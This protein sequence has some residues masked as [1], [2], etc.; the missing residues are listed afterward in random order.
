MKEY[1][2]SEAA[3]CGLAC[4]AAISASF[5]ATYDLR[6]LRTKFPLSL[7]GMSVLD[8]SRF[9]SEIGMAAR[10]LKVHITEVKKLTLPC[11]L[12]WNLNHF[13]VLEK[14]HRNSFTVMDPA[15][16]RIKVS[17]SVFHENFTG[18]A[19][20]FS[21]TA[22]FREK[23][24]RRTIPLRQLTGKVV[25]LKR[26]LAQ[27]IIFAIFLELIN[28]TAPLMSRFIVDDVLV[29]ADRDLL[30][31]II[32]GY[33]ILLILQTG[34]SYFRSWT[35]IS[36]SQRYGFQ[37]LSNVFTHLLRLPVGYFEKRHTGD[38]LSRF[39]TIGTIQ[40]L[41]TSSA[42][43]GAMDGVMALASLAMMF[44]VSPKLSAIVCFAVFLYS[45]SRILTLSWMRSTEAGRLTLAAKESTHFVETIRSIVP[46]RLFDRIDQR[47]AR[48]QNLIIDVQN[49]DA[50]SAIIT[51]FTGSVNKVIFGA[52]N[53]IIFW[54]GARMIL[55]RTPDASSQFTTGMLLSF[56]GYKV[57]F[58]SR[59]SS[60]IDFLAQLRLLSLYMDRLGDIVSE[61]PEV[62]LAHQAD[63]SHL[64]PEI[65]F[66]NISFRYTA[67]SP[68]VLKNLNFKIFAG[69]SVAIKGSSGSGK[70]TLLKLLLG[71][72]EPTSGDILYG[73]IPIRQLGLANYRRMIGA[74][75]QED[76]LMS[77][78][79]AE[80][81]SFFDVGPSQSLIEDCAQ[82][83]NIH[84]D[85]IAMPM[86][87]HSI[88]GDLG[89]GLSGGQKQRILLARALYKRPRLLV[90]DEATSHLDVKNE[91]EIS[92]NI[93]AQKMT[94][95]LVAHRPETIASAQRVIILRNGKIVPHLPDTHAAQDEALSALSP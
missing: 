22:T 77:G 18:I 62:D 44:M 28:L 46:L 68:L 42:V 48:W 93:A 74:V 23:R 43:E 92:R 53:L 52:E 86:G 67:N 55:E 69:E 80:N 16:G 31:I 35:L 29:S 61:Q 51:I 64:E 21:K 89:S 4:I 57:Q 66:R 24:A 81:I 19:I 27:V 82:L 87:Y 30:T 73:G 75:M 56:V 20:E 58:T 13:V 60:L 15:H 10:P 36:I 37:W 26:A 72:F 6:E 34:T 83:A 40:K 47:R 49:Y 78:S 65:E 71:L 1:V 17:T 63:I 84:K 85:I 90:L 14:I 33:A 25:G 91:R 41:L 70:T 32:I 79:L 12:H 45:I 7:K 5:G 9:S 2:Q 3:E 38:I 88:V 8:M 54:L 95:I 50:R 39:G 59:I 11:V 94:R 76:S